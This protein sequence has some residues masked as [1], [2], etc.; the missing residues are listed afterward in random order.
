MLMLEYH[1]SSYL[2][3]LSAIGCEDNS[4]KVFYFIIFKGF[5]PLLLGDVKEDCTT[6]F[7]KN[8]CLNNAEQ[9]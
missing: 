4:N 8:Y 6:F 7:K 1:F 3:H 2:E 5:K 9:H